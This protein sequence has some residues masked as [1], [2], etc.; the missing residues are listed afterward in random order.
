M[1][2][3]LHGQVTVGDQTFTKTRYF[4]QPGQLPDNY[5]E[6]CF[7]VMLGCNLSRCPPA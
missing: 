6:V 2:A 5:L 4:F 1:R 3:P 7:K